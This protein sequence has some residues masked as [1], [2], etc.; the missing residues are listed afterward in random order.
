MSWLLLIIELEQR[1]WQHCWHQTGF[2]QHFGRQGQLIMQLD[3][4]IVRFIMRIVLII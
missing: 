3:W 1:Y 2:K 4:L